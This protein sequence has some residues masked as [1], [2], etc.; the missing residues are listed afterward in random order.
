V[1]VA[2]RR[3]PRA[4]HLR[5]MPHQLGGVVTVTPIRDRSGEQDEAFSVSWH[6]PGGDLRWLS[7]RI[8]SQESADAAAEVLRDFTG[9]VLR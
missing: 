1:N 5:H 9:S 8:P 3:V 6:S 7:P 4:R 2:S